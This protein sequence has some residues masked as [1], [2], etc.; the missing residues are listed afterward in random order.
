M[1]T[2]YV[3]VTVLAAIANT[4]AAAVDFNRAGWVVANMT[5]Y[6]L[7]HSWLSPL[8]ALKAAG[9]LGLV[10]GI[11]VPMIGVAASVGLVLYFVGAVAAVTRARQ[12]S[13]LAFP[14][15]FLLLAMGSLALRLASL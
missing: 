2:A 14:S 13:H 4:F 7:P 8:G 5:R 12:T 6:G 11:G 9:A 15:V 1:F 3:V 10:V